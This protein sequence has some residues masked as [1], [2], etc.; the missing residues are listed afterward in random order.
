[1]TSDGS[2]ASYILKCRL[3]GTRG[4]K[5]GYMKKQIGLF[6]LLFVFTFLGCGKDDIIYETGDDLLTKNNITDVVKVFER[7]DVGDDMLTIYFGNRKGKDWFALF[8]A[9]SGLLKEEWYGKER[10]YENNGALDPSIS[11]TLPVFKK[12][13]NGEYIY[14]Y[15]FEDT[16]QIVCLLDNQEVRYGFVVKED[17]SLYN[18]LEGKG[19][20]GTK[21]EESGSYNHVIY[22]F[23]GNVCVSSVST[24]RDDS[25]TWY[26][27]FQED[28]VWIGI[29]DK[30]DNLKEIVGEDKFE[31][32]RK[33][34]IGYGEYEE[35]YIRGIERGN[36]IKTD[37]GYAFRPVYITEDGRRFSDVFLINKDRVIFIPL[38][39]S[40]SGYDNILRNWYNESILVSNK[41]VFSSEGKSIVE[42]S[43]ISIDDDDEP[44]SYREVIRFVKWGNEFLR[45]DCV[46]DKNIWQTKIDKLENIQFNARVTMT[47]LEKKGQIWGYCCNIVNEDG[48]KSEFKFNLNVETGEVTYL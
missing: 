34:H 38:A 22:D 10:F 43:G 5:I 21:N 19:F 44:V 20:Y 31:K 15:R 12:L 32:N 13:K 3:L 37:W 27:G 39:L 14:K 11:E 48:S 28:K 17:M 23:E 4:K 46:E 9:K 25:D 18:I 29:Y 35:F 41:Y 8:D 45:F 30:E 16:M 40:T 1:M 26:I 6:M 42:L 2:H 7:R 36:S 47:V 33:V 24:T